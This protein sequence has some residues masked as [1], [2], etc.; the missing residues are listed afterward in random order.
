MAPW[1]TEF[2]I[3]PSRA[4]ATAS[5]EL[6]ADTLNAG[7]WWAGV[8]L[9]AE[10]RERLS[11]VAPPAKSS[12]PDVEAW[13]APDGNYVEVRLSAGQPASVLA[14]VD[15]RRPDAKFAAGLLTF[16]RAA[17]A[18]LVRADGSVTEPTAGGFGAALRGSAAW[19]SVY[20]QA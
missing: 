9:P 12:S 13:G 16:T 19:R 6:T 20:P 10:Y 8:K 11:A 14:R 2:H 4:L 18:M 17:G 15:V 5:Q 1:Q 3:V 7:G